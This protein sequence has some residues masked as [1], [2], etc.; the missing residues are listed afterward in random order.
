MI[1]KLRAVAA[2]GAALMAAGVLA[3][4]AAPVQAAPVQAAP[5]SAKPAVV[6]DPGFCG[7]RQADYQAGDFHLYVVRNKCNQPWNFAV[8]LPSLNRRT[9]DGCKTVN[10]GEEVGYSDYWV[11]GLWAVINC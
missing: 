9:Q 10:P 4:G 11:D 5:V 1:N 2:F 8:Y 7:V 3:A 6:A